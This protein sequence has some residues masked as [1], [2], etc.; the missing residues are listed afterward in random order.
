MSNPHEQ[1]HLIEDHED[2][3]G[4]A[5]WAI[6]IGGAFLMITTVAIACGI[7]YRSAT[8]EAFDKNVNIRYEQRDMVLAA[9]QAVLEESAR[10]VSRENPSASGTIEHLV[11]P[12]DHAMDIV[13]G[14][15]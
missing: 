1:T 7:Y 5:T 14:N 9:Q 10:W 12:I 2:P 13:A 6:G 11:I 8:T 15:D 4:W 3:D